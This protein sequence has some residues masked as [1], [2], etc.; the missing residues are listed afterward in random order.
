MSNRKAPT[1]SRV[2][3]DALLEA[4]GDGCD[5]GHMA[6]EAWLVDSHRGNP[7]AG[8]TLR[9][10]LLA[11]AERYALAICRGDKA[12]AER[13]RGEIIGFAYRLECPEDANELKRFADHRRKERVEKVLRRSARKIEREEA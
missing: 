3:A 6:A 4:Y 1:K 13:A 9:Y 12:E 7:Q 2:H 5:R 8:G 10:V 11:M